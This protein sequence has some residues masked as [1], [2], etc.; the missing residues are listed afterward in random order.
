MLRQN[1]VKKKRGELNIIRRVVPVDF[2]PVVV[3]DDL[4]RVEPE[5]QSAAPAVIAAPAPIASPAPAPVVAPAPVASPTP[6]PTPAPVVTPVSI[7]S[8]AP[9]A[10]PLMSPN[11]QTPPLGS[12][13]IDTPICD[14][15]FNSQ[16]CPPQVPPTQISQHH[17]EI[18][19]SHSKI[20]QHQ[21]GE[22]RTCSDV[23]ESV[24]LLSGGGYPLGGVVTSM[25]DSDW[26]IAQY[27]LPEIL[28]LLVRA[29]FD[30]S[31]EWVEWGEDEGVRENIL[32][33]INEGLRKAYEFDD[34]L[35]ISIFDAALSASGSVGD[36]VRIRETVSQLEQFDDFKRCYAEA[37]SVNEKSQSVIAKRVLR[38]S[39]ISHEFQLLMFPR[40]CDLSSGFVS[41]CCVGGDYFLSSG[42]VGVVVNPSSDFL[43]GLNYVGGNILG[44]GNIVFTGGSRVDP[45]FLERL[46]FFAGRL[47]GVDL[48]NGSVSGSVRFRIFVPQEVK[49][50]LLRLQL[51][52]LFDVVSIP[53]DEEVWVSDDI[54]LVFGQGQLSVCFSGVQDDGTRK[55]NSVRFIERSAKPAAVGAGD[56]LVFVVDSEDGF[57]D[58][59][60][61][62]RVLGAGLTVFDL[63][64][65]LSGL[66][67]LLGVV[68]RY[69]GAVSVAGS[70]L[71]CDV[72]GGRFLD[73]V[74]CFD[75]D[76]D[77]WSSYADIAWSDDVQYFFSEAGKQKFADDQA[78]IIESF[79]ADRRRRYGL[80]FGM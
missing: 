22:L 75:V 49:D 72:G 63:P 20:S 67:K 16:S 52:E 78:E 2:V 34:K 6:A 58:A 19:Q 29:G 18:S 40:V 31:V 77:R 8:P 36:N 46:R 51:G 65:H 55:L 12:V 74:K 48:A 59:V 9:V 79:Q 33:L 56:V 26:R 50:D 1:P 45:I 53:V 42:G 27:R 69:V 61:L 47:S 38:E 15:S 44:L 76:S 39:R 10:A 13:Q 71:V 57:F 64:Q 24:N 70:N 73:V 14:Q 37:V 28:S 54:C 80:Y 30:E 23:S 35:F 43:G 41:G 60:G 25:P 4:R 17:S 21:S 3:S 62:S 11:L 7:A 32:A 68:R 66:S 5:S